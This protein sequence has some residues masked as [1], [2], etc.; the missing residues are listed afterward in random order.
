MTT[1][2]T[3]VEQERFI[4]YFIRRLGPFNFLT[5]PR[6][7]NFQSAP[8]SPIEYCTLGRLLQFRFSFKHKDR[9]QY[10]IQEIAQQVDGDWKASNQNGFWKQGET[11]TQNH[12]YQ[13]IAFLRNEPMNHSHEVGLNQDLRR[14]R[15]FVLLQLALPPSTQ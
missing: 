4:A 10:Y 3:T 2:P 7:T 12:V 6:V 8:T 15:D 5:I 9:D 13:L 14:S 1:I 11:L